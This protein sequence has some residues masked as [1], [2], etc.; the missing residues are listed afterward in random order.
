MALSPQYA[1]YKKALDKVNDRMCRE[2]VSYTHLTMIL[3]LVLTVIP[4]RADG[5]EQT[6]SN[7]ASETVQ[8]CIADRKS[9]V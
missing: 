4:V 3:S 8:Q 2:P 9:V 6:P 1:E 5:V 7:E